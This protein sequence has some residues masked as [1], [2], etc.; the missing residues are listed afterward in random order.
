MPNPPPA[1]PPWLPPLLV[2]GAI[3]LL[4]VPLM[5]LTNWSG[6]QDL[7][8]R[9]N[10]D[11]SSVFA[12]AFQ[13]RNPIIPS[14]P[15]LLR[16]F[17][18]MATPLFSTDTVLFNGLITL[19]ETLLGLALAL[20]LGLLT[21]T[22]LVMSRASERMI[23]PWIVASQNV[24]IVA[25][26]PVLAVLLG[27]Y[28]VQGLLP[29][30]IVAAYIAFFPLSIGIAKGLRSVPSLQ[31][32]LMHTYHARAWQVYVWLRL[33]IALPILLTSLK[34][35]AAMALVGSIV[36]EISIVSFAGLGPMLLSRSYYSDMVGLWVIMLVAAGLGIGLV[37]SID[38]L[39][40]RLLFWQRQR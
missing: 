3:L 25:L 21:A 17:Y 36:A 22:L 18:Q 10:A 29:K 14:P 40:K 31:L 11:C 15:Q 13:L 6:S 20:T 16:G 1:T 26:A 9:G 12:C 2:G 35:S 37:Q 28:G 23:L 8:A 24:P 19:G 38:L 34:I 30:G 27:Q 39:E 4:W 33:P 32:D 5:L 7:L